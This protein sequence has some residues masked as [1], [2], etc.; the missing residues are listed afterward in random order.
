MIECLTS[1]WPGSILITGKFFSIFSKPQVSKLGYRSFQEETSLEDI[2]VNMYMRVRIYS[3]KMQNSFGS[4]FTFAAFISIK[5]RKQN[6]REKRGKLTLSASVILESSSS[7]LLVLRCSNEFLCCC[8][9]CF[10]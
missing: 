3:L 5:I 7:H 1:S 2:D 6:G 9:R 8:L 4:N 10:P